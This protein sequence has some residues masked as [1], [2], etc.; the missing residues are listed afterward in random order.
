[1]NKYLFFLMLVCFGFVNAQTQNGFKAERF[2]EGNDT[3]HYQ[4]LYPEHFSK[5][6][7]Y[8]VVLFLHGAGERG[9]D[10][11]SQLIHGSTLFLADSIQTKY[12]AI[13][14]FPQCPK[15]DYWANAV[16][17][18]SSFPLNITFKNGGEPTKALSLVM[19]LI[20]KTVQES[21]VKKDQVYVMGL[22]MGGMGTFEI[23]YRKPNMFA[24]AIAICGGAAPETA[25]VYAKTLPIWIFHGAEDNVVNPQY[26]LQMVSAILK[27][28]GHPQYTLYEHAN[29]NSWDA[30]FAQPKL[31]SWLFSKHKITSKATK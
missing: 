2:V 4:I 31:L 1:M 12:P 13:V 26:S 10:N 24:A 5:Q 25:S 14:I 8:P 7:Q 18:R 19:K 16:I 30:T 21:Y 28:G 17:D 27:D 15:N 9:N 20:D 6:K 22:S 23:I 3:L 11:T 29:H